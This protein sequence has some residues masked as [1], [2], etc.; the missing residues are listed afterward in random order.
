MEMVGLNLTSVGEDNASGYENLNRN[1][2]QVLPPAGPDYGLDTV[3]T[4]LAYGSQILEAREGF[5]NF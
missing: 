1:L 4:Y 3:D 2:K 5:K